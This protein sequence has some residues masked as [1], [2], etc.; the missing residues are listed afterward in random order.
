[1][2]AVLITSQPGRWQRQARTAGLAA[3]NVLLLALHLLVAV[4]VLAVRIPY[5]LLGI[6]ARAAAT[7]ELRLSARTGRTPLGQT[8]GV[9]I[10][11]A[12]THEF[13]AGY[14]AATPTIR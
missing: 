14:T 4:L 6:A 8:I 7:A 9:T 11:A 3:V 5:T 12:F 2:P 1:M 10:A 13:R